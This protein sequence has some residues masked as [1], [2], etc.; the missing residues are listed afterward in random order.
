MDK[1]KSLLEKITDTVKDVASI[2]ADAANYALTTEEPP[3]K[4]DQKAIAYMPVPTDG[5]VADPMMVA[6]I[7]P[8]RKRKP[9]T[10]KRSPT[11]AG[12]KTSKKAAKKSTATKSKKTARNAVKKTARKTAKNARKKSRKS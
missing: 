2:A 1:E 12:K 10:A 8:A 6:P 9:A 5:L 3:L 4:A 11:K 7:A